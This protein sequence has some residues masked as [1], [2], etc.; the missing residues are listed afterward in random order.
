[1]IAR[2]L[3]GER[4]VLAL[5]GGAFVDPKTRALVRE[6]ALSIWLRADLDVLVRRT[7]RRDDRPLLAGG[8]PRARLAALLEQRAPI[9]AEADLVVDSGKG[10]IGDGRG[11]GARGAGRLTKRGHRERAPPACGS[12]WPTGA[13]TSWSAR[14]CWRAPARSWRL[15]GR[16]RSGH[17]DRRRISPRPGIWRGSRRAS[18]PPRCAIAGSSCRPAKPARAW[19]SSRRCW[20]RCSRPGSSARPRSSAFG[21]GVIGDLAGFCAAILLRGV[22]LRAGPDSAARPGRQRGRRQD[23]RQRAPRQ[24]PDRRL[25]SAQA[26]AGRHRRAG[27]RCRRASCAPA[28]PR[29]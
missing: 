17:R 14:A 9:Y 3:R 12:I 6:R 21:G 18:M 29:W 20:I 7:A 13:T 2:L 24:E 15:L 1:M 22:A 10:P 16:A 27:A 26:G 28:M 4:Q 5:G 23:R 11:A 19:R 8:D 25:P